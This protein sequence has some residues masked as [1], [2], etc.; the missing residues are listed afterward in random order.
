MAQVQI[1]EIIEHLDY[2]IKNALERAINREIPNANFNKN[3]LFR[4][5][6]RAVYMKCNQW[7]DVP[8]QYVKL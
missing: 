2:E 6:V 3:R 4:E 5:F 7:E 1:E 8:D